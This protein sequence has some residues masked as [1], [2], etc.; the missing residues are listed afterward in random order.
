MV[1]TEY[2]TAD[3]GNFETS[4][5]ETLL[6]FQGQNLPERLWAKDPSLWKNDP[7]VQEKIK[8]RLGWLSLAETMPDAI[9]TLSTFAASIKNEGFT[10]VLLLGMGGS[11]LCPEVLNQTFG[12]A[13]GYP[14]LTV[15]D[16]TDPETIRSAEKSSEL[17]TTLFI[18]ASKSGSTIE[19]MSLYRYFAERLSTVVGNT[20]GKQ[21]IAITDPGS[22]LETLAKEKGFR[23]IFST[24]PDVGGRYSALTYFGLVPAAL[25]GIDLSVFLK[26]AQVMAQASG[27]SIAPESNPGILLG[28]ILGIFGIAKRDK[29]TIVPSQSLSHFGIWVEQLIAESTGKE[30]KGLVPI[31]GEILGESVVYGNDR[32]F[33]YLRVE[34]DDCSVLDQRISTL[35]KSAHPV[36]R[37]DLKDRYDLAGEFFRW[38]MATA[39]AGILLHV[40]PFDEPNVSESKENT[41][42]VLTQFEKTG[43]LALP[44]ALSFEGGIRMTGDGS[45]VPGEREGSKEKPSHSLALALEAFLSASNTQT[46]VALMAYLA[47]SKRHG[48]LLG[49]L[50]S[51]IRDRYHV[52]T[53]LGY[54]PRFLHSTGQLHKGGGRNGRFIQ[55]TIDEKQ[56][57]TIPGAPYSF[58]ILKR[59]QALGDFHSLVRHRLHVL[60]IRLGKDVETGLEW[61]LQ[62]L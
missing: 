46:Y 12:P 17:K 33:I 18:L 11:S 53:T 59:A 41:A 39:V 49:R 26:R 48:L 15:L 2:T 55:I 1:N 54:G 25:L 56:D 21:F 35:Q 20:L 30:G 40:N 42:T 60:D 43:R 6:S 58:G 45:S 47:P 27:A 50:R 62:A 51:R 61:V 38:E 22:P 7:A 9:E 13:P 57:I 31:D 37:I 23:R 8:N 14:R 24:P 3:L 19:V 44:D 10:D 36:V 29:I 4:L 32:V 5:R 28:A 52:A 34:T 16:T